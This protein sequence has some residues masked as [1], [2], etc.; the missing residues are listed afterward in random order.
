M[1][2]K[3]KSTPVGSVDEP[4]NPITL[5]LGA[6]ATFVA[7]TTH[8]LPG[9]MRE[10]ILAAARHKG[11]AFV[12]IWQNCVIFNDGVYEPW[13]GKDVRDDK[14]L[15]LRDGEP[16]V[17]GKD[18]ERGIIF[19]CGEPREVPAAEASIWR[20]NTPTSGPATVI[21]E[22]DLY[23]NLPRAIGIFRDV[24]KPVYDREIH[25]QIETA[26]AAHP[27]ADLKDLIYTKDAWE[28]K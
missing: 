12:E 1:G 8:A 23:E 25:R 10:V 26:K 3:T 7:R 27:N 18:G 24:E 17:F 15:H 2:T 9:H 11:T 4:F 16:M 5:A 22:M 13:V 20:S 6:R 28:V 14:L 21:A 19:D